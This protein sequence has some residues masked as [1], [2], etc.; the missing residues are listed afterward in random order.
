MLLLGLLERV[1][2]KNKLTAVLKQVFH[3]KSVFL[4]DFAVRFCLQTINT[5]ALDVCNYK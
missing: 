2:D 4:F 3:K 5:T 1:D